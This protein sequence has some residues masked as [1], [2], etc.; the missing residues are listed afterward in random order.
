MLSA[1]STRRR[2]TSCMPTSRA[3]TP[4]AALRIPLSCSSETDGR[5]SNA[6][7]S[8]VVVTSSIRRCAYDAPLVACE[9]L[10]AGAPLD[11]GG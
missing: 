2:L 10:D 1:C 8:D 7:S 6:L 3:L 4:G 11:A 5:R 9:P